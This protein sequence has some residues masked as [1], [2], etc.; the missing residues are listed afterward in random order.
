MGARLVQVRSVTTIS[1]FF[2]DIQIHGSIE[3]LKILFDDDGGLRLNFSE[4][5][6]PSHAV[7][8]YHN[9]LLAYGDLFAHDFKLLHLYSDA[10]INF[11]TAVPRLKSR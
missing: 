11:V 8:I 7:G 5:L 2:G 3:N 4:G 6:Y 9:D 10:G 1:R